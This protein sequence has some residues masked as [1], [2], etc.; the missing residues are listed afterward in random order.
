MFSKFA[1]TLS[2][3]TATLVNGLSLGQ[4]PQHQRQARDGMPTIVVPGY[5]INVT[6]W[7]GTTSELTTGTWVH[8]KSR[9]N[10]QY[11]QSVNDGSFQDDHGMSKDGRYGMGTTDANDYTKFMVLVTDGDSKQI[12][13]MDK[14]GYCYKRFYSDAQYYMSPGND[15]NNCDEFALLN[16]KDAADGKGFLLTQGGY[17]LQSILN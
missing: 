7:T 9:A 12:Q 4:T 14:D 6:D 3:A 10:N 5:S 2:V 15:V 1:I 17:S 8:L 13:L 11:F 16:I